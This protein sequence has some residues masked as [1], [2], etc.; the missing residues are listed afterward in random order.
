MVKFGK[1]LSC[2]HQLC[3]AH[4]IHLAV[5][6]V[7]YKKRAVNDNNDDFDESIPLMTQQM[8]PMRTIMKAYN[9]MYVL[10]K[11][12]MMTMIPL[13]MSEMTFTIQLAYQRLLKM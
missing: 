13:V 4:A 5:V 1:L 8:I 2:E 12:V 11:I 10:S 9:Q 7:L 3:Y 6:D